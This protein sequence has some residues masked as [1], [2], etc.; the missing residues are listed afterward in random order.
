MTMTG[1]AAAGLLALSVALGGC[2]TRES[3]ERAQASADTAESHAGAAMG[4]AN[5]AWDVGNNALG[6]GHDAQS[7][8]MVAAQKADQANADLSVA[9]ERIAYL[10]SK[11]LPHKKKHH[12]RATQPKDNS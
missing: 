9:K 3:V 8:A 10:E 4:R 5:E 12:R 2:A 6:V 11:T 7:M 1:K